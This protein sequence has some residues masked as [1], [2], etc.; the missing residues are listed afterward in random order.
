MSYLL[1]IS[2]AVPEFSATKEELV[3]FYAKSLEFEGLPDI[4]KKLRL[5]CEKTKIHNRNSCVPDFNNKNY[6]LYDAGN[7]QQ[8]VEKR[9]AV[10]KQKVMPLIITLIKQSSA[11]RHY[12]PHNR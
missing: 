11:A 9:M 1:D 12:A 7:C 2:T 10:F 3:T 8:S 6:E 4:S 5:L